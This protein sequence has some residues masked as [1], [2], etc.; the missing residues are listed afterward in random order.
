MQ[1]IKSDVILLNA[2]GQEVVF[3]MHLILFVVISTFMIYVWAWFSDDI[4]WFY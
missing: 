3:E 4:F 2:V 1:Q